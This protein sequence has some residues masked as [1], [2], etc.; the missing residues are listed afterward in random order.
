MTKKRDRSFSPRPVSSNNCL[1]KILNNLNNLSML[2]PCQSHALAYTICGIFN[3]STIIN[4]YNTYLQG[5]MY[6]FFII[7]TNFYSI[8]YFCPVG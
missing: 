3:I 8:F 2:I 6:L 1:S 4:L 7:R 5:F